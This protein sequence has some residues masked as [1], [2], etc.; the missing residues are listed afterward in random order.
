MKSK[1]Y[2]ES[3]GLFVTGVIVGVS[4]GWILKNKILKTLSV[5]QSLLTSVHEGSLSM[6]LVL[7]AR[8]DLGMGKGKLA[9]QCAHA[10]IGCYQEGLQTCPQIIRKWELMGQPKIVVKPDQDGEQCLIQ[11]HEKAKRIGLVT[12]I[13]R[14][15]GRTQL[16]SGTVTVVGIGPG[17]VHLVDQVTKHLKLL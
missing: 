13:V 16:E 17:K 3:Y 11:L 6:K 9:S 5:F 15:A 14:D 12:A 1:Q 2:F 8:T 4:A 10:A 7:V